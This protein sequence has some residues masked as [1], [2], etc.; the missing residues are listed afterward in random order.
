MNR[1]EVAKCAFPRLTLQFK[2]KLLKASRKYAEE[3]DKQVKSGFAIFTV[4]SGGASNSRGNPMKVFYLVLTAIVVELISASNCRLAL[5]QA[6]GAPAPTV[7][8]NTLWHFLGIPQGYQKVRDA[9][10]N[11]RGNNPQRE[12]KPPL[13]R[14]ADPANMYSDNPAIKTA[15]NI[16]AQ[17]DLAPQKVKAIKYLATVGCACYPGVREA[18]LDALDDCTEEVRYEA[19]IALC[20]AA[21]N[22]CHICG[23]S[24][25]N[26]EVMSKLNDMAYG[27]DDK[28]CYKEPSARVRAAAE[29]ALNA[30][31]NKT[32]PST[33]PMPTPIEEPTAPQKPMEEPTAPKGGGTI[34]QPAPHPAAPRELPA[35]PNNQPQGRRNSTMSYP[36]SA[37][38]PPPTHQQPNKLVIYAG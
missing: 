36:P 35:E 25:C 11:R 22:P 2:G 19:A 34:E 37:P 8:G 30:C 23:K 5:A 38:L 16:K 18:L 20:Q 31:K 12:R 29:N 28:C 21:G 6:P 1:H 9:E 4:K 26:A 27:Q 32:G 7:T 33:A 15:A 14:I 10:V 17:E 24:C 13:K 3:S